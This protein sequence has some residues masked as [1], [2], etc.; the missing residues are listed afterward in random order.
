MSKDLST[1]KGNMK[2]RSKRIAVRSCCIFTVLVF[3]LYLMTAVILGNATFTTSIGN[4]T[5]LFALSLVLSV[6]TVFLDEKNLP[7]WKSNLILFIAGGAVYYFIVVFL[8]GMHKNIRSAL[9]AMGIYVFAFAVYS[10]VK[11]IVKI[12]KRKQA[13]TKN[14]KEYESKF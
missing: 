6:V 1:N 13:E 12:S 11:F 10:A 9:T 5:A 4:T 2:V 8:S 14:N 7:F 3:A